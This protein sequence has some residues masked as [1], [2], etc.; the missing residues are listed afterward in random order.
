MRTSGTGWTS[1]LAGGALMPELGRG[2]S[3]LHD[4]AHRTT[5]PPGP[6]RVRRASSPATPRELAL[7]RT[8]LRGRPPRSASRPDRGRGRAPRERSARRPP[9]AAP[10]ARRSGETGRAPGREGV[11]PAWSRA[12]GDGERHASSAGGPRQLPV[13]EHVEP[14]RRVR[15]AEQLELRE[16]LARELHRP[17]AAGGDDPVVA[18]RKDGL[19]PRPAA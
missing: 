9:A 19:V 15:G 7:A 10:R 5:E 1:R 13:L 12:Y 8:P 16:D 11:G 18:H 4:D 2:V 3:A 17:E 14:E 6:A